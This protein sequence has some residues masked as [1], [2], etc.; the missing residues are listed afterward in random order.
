MIRYVI[1]A[2]V[3]IKW[4]VPENPEEP[5]VP[6]ALALLDALKNGDI[7][8]YQPA[9]WEAEIAGVLARISPANAIKKMVALRALAFTRVNDTTVYA[10]ACNLAIRLNHHLF[11]TLYHAVALHTTETTLIT[12]DYRYFDKAQSIGQIIRLCDLHLHRPT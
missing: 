11:D 10:T 3:A 9:H 6:Q 4:F 12:A 5:D 8:L 1:D 7:A 2:S